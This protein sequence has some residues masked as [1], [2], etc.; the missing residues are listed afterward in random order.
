MDF[1]SNN[2][3]LI[4]PISDI[5]AG[6]INGGNSICQLIDSVVSSADEAERNLEQR[7]SIVSQRVRYLLR[8]LKF[9]KS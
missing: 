9:L 7:T 8:A 4:R 3:D 2:H 5:K 1:Y 6:Q